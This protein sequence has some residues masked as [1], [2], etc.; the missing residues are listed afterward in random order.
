[1]E[2]AR[3]WSLRTHGWI[4]YLCATGVAAGAYVLTNVAVV[5]A[6]IAMAVGASGVA[7]IVLGI[8]L[9]RPVERFPWLLLGGVHVMWAIGWPLWEGH[10]LLEGTPPPTTSLVNLLF[11][12]SYLPLT[13]LLLLLGKRRYPDIVAAV[14]VAIIAAG[15]AAVAWLAFGADQVHDAS[16]PPLGRAIQGAYALF[17]IILLAIILRLTITRG[18]ATASFWLLV[19]SPQLGSDVEPGAARHHHVEHDEVRVLRLREGERLVA[20]PCFHEL[21]P[22][23]VERRAHQRPEGSLIVADEDLRR[24]V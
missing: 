2:R 21:V 7:A 1:M 15:L 10:I 16:V 4:A 23:V 8:R 5:Q 17:D 19:A 22:P 9:N 13:V 14:D 18:S 6:A 20:V 12:G 24:H 3:T 11:I